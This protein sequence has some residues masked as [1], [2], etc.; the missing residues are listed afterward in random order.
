MTK[1]LHMVYGD[2]GIKAQGWQ[3]SAVGWEQVDWSDWANGSYLVV[4]WPAAIPAP[5]KDGPPRE[6]W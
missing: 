4:N 2:N 5:I 3:Q 6:R 1:E